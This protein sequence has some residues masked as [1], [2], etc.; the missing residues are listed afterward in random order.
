MLKRMLYVFSPLVVVF[1]TVIL[2][3]FGDKKDLLL[4]HNG[5]DWRNFLEP[6]IWHIAITQALWSSQIAGGYL[7]SSAG[8]IYSNTDVQWWVSFSLFMQIFIDTN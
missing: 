8:T 1:A 7:V 4:I 6:Y 2:S 3:S 5:S